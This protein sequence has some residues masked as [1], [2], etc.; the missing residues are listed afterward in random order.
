MSNQAS[1]SSVIP[2]PMSLK[3][4]L[5]VE[6]DPEMR[7]FYRDYLAAIYDVDAAENG[8]EGLD[9]LSKN[10][11]DL[12]MLDVMMPQVDGLT[13]LKRKNQIPNIEKVPVVMLTNLGNDEIIK[14]C[15]E[16][17]AKSYIFKA[18]TT[19]DKILPTLKQ[20]IEDSK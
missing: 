10:H 5:I 19:P 12:V 13:F 8:E 9:K 2:D 1:T 16:L 15:F 6:D 4:I 20:V 18:E 11:Y 14:Q 3:K 7:N 17:G